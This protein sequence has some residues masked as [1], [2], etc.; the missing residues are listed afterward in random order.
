MFS[1]SGESSDTNSLSATDD[2][3]DRTFTHVR[4]TNCTHNQLLF[5]I[6]LVWF[7]FLI[8]FFGFLKHLL[9]LSF[10]NCNELLSGKD[11]LSVEIQNHSFS[12]FKPSF[13]S[14]L[15]SF[16]GRI[17][18]LL[19]LNFKFHFRLFDR[20]FCNQ[21]LIIIHFIIWA[22]RLTCITIFLAFTLLVFFH[23]I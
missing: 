18:S 21:F 6:F 17:F 12:F 8:S 9:G 19:S 20:V 2:V 10:K 4:V 11:R 1:L 14:Q 22:T 7:I 16:S 3:D 23:V 13:F 5:Y 15:F